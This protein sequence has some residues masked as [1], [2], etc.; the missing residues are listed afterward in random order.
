MTGAAGIG[1]AIQN[2]LCRCFAA[3]YLPAP[4]PRR[5]GGVD[6]RCG[7]SLMTAGFFSIRYSRTAS[8]YGIFYDL[9]QVDYHHELPA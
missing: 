7:Y 1:V 9:A 2:I 8:L 4:R 5:S 3:R 6:G